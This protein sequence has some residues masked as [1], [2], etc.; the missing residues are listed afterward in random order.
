[1]RVDGSLS[2]IAKA[3]NITVETWTFYLKTVDAVILNREKPLGVQTLISPNK[4]TG[5]IT[6][7]PG[8]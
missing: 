7:A 5:L 3:K 2:N 6:L 1:M 8:L 4:T